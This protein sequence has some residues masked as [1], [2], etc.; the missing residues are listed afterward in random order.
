MVTLDK[1]DKTAD[2]VTRTFKV[3]KVCKSSS[4]FQRISREQGILL[5]L[6]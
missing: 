4:Y 3:E 6:R 2:Y 1:I 5:L